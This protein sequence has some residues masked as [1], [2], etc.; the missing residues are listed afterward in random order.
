M[1]DE[2][3]DASTLVTLGQAVI[4]LSGASGKPMTTKTC[5][6]FLK[7]LIDGRAKHLEVFSLRGGYAY[8]RG[9]AEDCAGLI[10]GLNGDYSGAGNSLSLH[11][12]M[13]EKTFADV[14]EGHRLALRSDAASA[15]FGLVSWMPPSSAEGPRASAPVAKRLKAVDRNME[16]L[17]SAL[18]AAGLNPMEL[19]A[20]RNGTANPSKTLAREALPNMTASAFD[21]AWSAL[22]KAHSSEG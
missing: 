5:R 4:L 3:V 1:H 9:V 6:E 8:S 19:P 12:L 11:M 20:Y 21:R 22:R 15:A 17:R 18:T 16:L 10:S 13:H 14:P 2:E 7:A